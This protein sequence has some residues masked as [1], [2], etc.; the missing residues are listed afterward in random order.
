MARKSVGLGVSE[1]VERLFARA[2]L[3]APGERLEVECASEGEAKALQQAFYRTRYR[4]Q[5]E[6]VTS[7]A[8]LD[9]NAADP[10]RGFSSV[11]AIEGAKRI[12]FAISRAPKIENF[13]IV[14]ADGTS[15]KEKLQ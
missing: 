3:L 10:W 11:V 6:A 13:V 5:A 8:T 12:I 7:G 4:A 15:Y 14:Q 1:D 2:L 9:A